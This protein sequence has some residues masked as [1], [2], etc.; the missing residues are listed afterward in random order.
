[1]E[2]VST[3]DVSQNVIQ[4]TNDTSAP[5][6]I[7]LQ[8]CLNYEVNQNATYGGHAGLALIQSGA[9]SNVV[10]QNVI[11]NCG[12]YAIGLDNIASSSVQITNNAFGECGLVDTGS[13]IY[14]AAIV[15]DGNAASGANTVIANNAYQGHANG[16]DWYVTVTFTAPH[17]PAANVT[18]NTQTQTVLMN[19][20]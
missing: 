13:S 4:L 10:S 12:T 17:I 9:G 1:M 16:L 3:L 5:Y 19:Q 6:A 20:I 7:A 11:R 18:G 2:S 14:N 15:V 8:G